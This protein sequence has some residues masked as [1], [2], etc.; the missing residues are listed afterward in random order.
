VPLE[1]FYKAWLAEP[2]LQDTFDDQACFL[3]LA[4]GLTGRPAEAEAVF[5]RVGPWSRCWAFYGDVLA[6]LGDEAG[7]RRVWAQGLARLPDLPMIYL[8]RGQFELDHGNLAAAAA[9]L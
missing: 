5:K 6:R 9:D 8:H 1:A 4:Y 2:N 3:G 7:A